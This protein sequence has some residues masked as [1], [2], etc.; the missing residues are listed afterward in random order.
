MAQLLHRTSANDQM[1]ACKNN[2]QAQLMCA[3]LACR[4]SAVIVD[5]T[6]K[7]LNLVRL[8]EV[9]AAQLVV[10]DEPN[11]MALNSNVSLCRRLMAQ[12]LAAVCQTRL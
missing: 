1:L 8:S 5:N 11:S 7:S 4:F 2:K 12:A 10:C 9:I 6:I 3:S